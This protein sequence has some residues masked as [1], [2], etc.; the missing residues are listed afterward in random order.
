M[1]SPRQITLRNVSPELARR[2]KGLAE[3][4]GTSVNTAVLNLLE[5][6]L[7][8][9]E[10]RRRLEERYGTWTEQD[11]QEFEVALKA[12]RSVDDELWQ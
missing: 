12:Q 9:D 4:E 8:V 1:E 5:K 11:F 10:R 7:G 2:L 3:A 6:A